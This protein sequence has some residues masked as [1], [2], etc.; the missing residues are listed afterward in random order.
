MPSRPFVATYRFS[1]LDTEQQ[2]RLARII[3]PKN[4]NSVLFQ[5]EKASKDG[6]DVTHDTSVCSMR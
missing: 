1:M 6:E 3:K 2:R 5:A 4:K